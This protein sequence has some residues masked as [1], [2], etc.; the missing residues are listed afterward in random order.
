[1]RSYISTCRKQSRNLLDELEKAIVGTPFI[2]S[3]PAAGP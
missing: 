3:A 2:P 1:M